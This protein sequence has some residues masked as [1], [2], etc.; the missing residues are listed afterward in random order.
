MVRQ[1]QAAPSLIAASVQQRAGA[2]P[3]FVVRRAST[4][5]W[6]IASYRPHPTGVIMSS[7]RDIRVRDSRNWRIA[8]G[9]HSTFGDAAVIAGV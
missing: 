2:L 4:S 5:P 9:A 8:A 3:P 1:F 6:P 7:V